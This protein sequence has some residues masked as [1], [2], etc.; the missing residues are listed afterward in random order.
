M[1]KV[2]QSKSLFEWG[3]AFFRD[4]R[5]ANLKIFPGLATTFNRL[6]RA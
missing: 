4:V 6:I 1:G 3:H 5:K 2:N